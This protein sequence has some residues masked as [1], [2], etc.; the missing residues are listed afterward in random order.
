MQL[1]IRPTLVALIPFLLPLTTHAVDPVEKKDLPPVIG[2]VKLKPPV[3]LPKFAPHVARLALDHEYFRKNPGQDYWDLSAYYVSQFNSKACSVASVTA[4]LNAL[5]VNDSLT[6]KDELFT[7]DSVLKLHK[8][9][10]SAVGKT[11]KGL[12]LDELS[13]ATQE[14][15]A[16]ALPRHKVTIETHRFDGAD[17]AAELKK[18]IALLEKNEKQGSRDYI[19]ANFLQAVLT[20]DPEGVGHISPIGAYDSDKKRVL[21]FDVDRQYYEPYWVPVEVFLKAMN[22]VDS[23]AKKARGLIYI[24]KQ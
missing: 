9:F 13:Q 18:L 4:L 6:A 7:Q 10:A 1:A 15:L 19:I 3:E 2:A 11:G 16:K 22:E 17:Q 5:R 24:Q 20:G 12:A 23:G 8:K 21:V 14:L